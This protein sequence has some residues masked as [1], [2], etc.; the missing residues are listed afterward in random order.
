MQTRA[1]L[2]LSVV[3]LLAAACA[4][5]PS[6]PIVSG[7][8]PSPLQQVTSGDLAARLGLVDP[9]YVS[10]PMTATQQTF[11]DC[12][13]FPREGCGGKRAGWQTIVWYET[14]TLTYRVSD[15]YKLVAVDGADAWLNP[16]VVG[17]DH[18][19]RVFL[20]GHVGGS[21]FRVHYDPDSTWHLLRPG[22]GSMPD[23]DVTLTQDQ[24]EILSTLAPEYSS[25]YL[26]TTD[27]EELDFYGLGSIVAPSGED[28]DT[29]L[30]LAAELAAT[31]R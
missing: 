8:P 18:P 21:D 15:D 29:L 24:A 26:R 14:I 20:Q 28:R 7:N 30:A 17:Q 1:S 13:A 27:G 4:P 3:L 25:L 12:Q 2:G 23:S 5:L 16:W 22:D 19:Q 9:F 10:V 31:P 6:G 11:D